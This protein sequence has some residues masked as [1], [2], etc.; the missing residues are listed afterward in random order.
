[1]HRKKHPSDSDSF[2]QR[3]NRRAKRLWQQHKNL[4]KQNMEPTNEAKSFFKFYDKVQEEV[5]IRPYPTQALGRKR[6]MFLKAMALDEDKFREWVQNRLYRLAYDNKR[7]ISDFTPRDI[8]MGLQKWE[9]TLRNSD[10]GFGKYQEQFKAYTD[11]F[12]KTATALLGNEMSGQGSKGVEP[13]EAPS[14]SAA[15]EPVSPTMM[16]IQV[17]GSGSPTPTQDM[18]APPAEGEE[19]QI[20]PE[21]ETFLQK[22]QELEEILSLKDRDFMDHVENSLMERGIDIETANPVEIEEGLDEEFQELL[23]SVPEGSQ[24]TQEEQMIEDLYTQYKERFFSLLEKM[25]GKLAGKMVKADKAAFQQANKLK[26][27][28]SLFEIGIVAAAGSAS[29][30]DLSQCG[31]TDMDLKRLQKDSVTYSASRRLMSNLFQ[32]YPQLAKA[33]PYWMGRET[34]PSE[35]TQE[36]GASDGTSVSDIVFR[37]DKRKMKFKNGKFVSCSPESRDEK[38][39]SDVKIL[40][41]INDMAIVPKNPKDMKAVF[42][43]MIEN[44]RMKD[45]DITNESSLYQRLLADGME[46]VEARELSQYIVENFQIMRSEFDMVVRSPDARKEIKNYVKELTMKLQNIIHMLPG[47][48]QEYVFAALSGSGK[49]VDG[50]LREANFILSSDENGDRMVLV[51]LDRTLCSQIAEQGEMSFNVMP[52]SI[53]KKDPLLKKYTDMGLSKEE[54]QIKIEEE[55]PFRLNQLLDATE[56]AIQ[57]NMMIDPTMAG[58]ILPESSILYSFMKNMRSLREEGEAVSPQ[59]D[60]E[61]EQYIIAATNYA[62]SSITN[63]IRFFGIEF[64]EVASTELNLFNMFYMDQPHSMGDELNNRIDMNNQLVDDMQQ[65]AQE[66]GVQNKWFQYKQKERPSV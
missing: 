50:S 46:P 10:P 30:I 11:R 44:L 34:N 47:I 54:A 24:Y 41:K 3:R 21:E 32:S 28:P 23:D 63:I 62:F 33:M 59:I 35:L 31:L 5:S 22:M 49:F 56:Q 64:G 15:N 36:W 18:S 14:I 20:L 17:Q 16:N 8:T 1:M 4:I 26:K 61:T 45:Y 6:N 25:Q 39:I 48:K 65:N 57:A 19:P 42:G 13:S 37:F 27:D 51:P 40:L 52:P 2:G 38:C 29:G 60:P 12:I 58:S 9:G 7:S 55:H 43:V 66:N 53:S